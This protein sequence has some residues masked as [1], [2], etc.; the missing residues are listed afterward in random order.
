MGVASKM[1]A[2]LF[3]YYKGKSDGKKTERARATAKEA[4]I[5][6]KQRDSSIHTVA[7]SDNFWLHKSGD[8]NT[9]KR[10]SK[11]RNPKRK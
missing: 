5:L 10:L 3:L 2:P 8:R 9:H 7:D 1:L 11:T 6:K 4:A